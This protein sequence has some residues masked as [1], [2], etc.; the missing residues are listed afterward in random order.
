M[1]VVVIFQVDLHVAQHVSLQMMTNKFVNFIVRFVD[2]IIRFVDIIISF[3]DFIVRF[4]DF[5]ILIT[6]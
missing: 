6:T 4:M 3:V 5:I 1:E 2:V